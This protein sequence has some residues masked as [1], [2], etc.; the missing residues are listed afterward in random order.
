VLVVRA[1]GEPVLCHASE[2]A[3]DLAPTAEVM[4]AARRAARAG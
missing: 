4:A 3:G 1:G 2:E